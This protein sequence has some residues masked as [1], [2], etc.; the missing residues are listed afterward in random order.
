M[1]AVNITG[2]PHFV[3]NNLSFPMPVMVDWG[4]FASAPSAA[5]SVTELSSKMIW[6]WP[7]PPAPSLQSSQKQEKVFDGVAEGSK[8]IE[9]AP[10]L[11]LHGGI[12]EAAI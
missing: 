4:N 7:G 12:G 6:L 3:Q 11:H 5:V 1:L 10:Q 2:L 9:I 8:T